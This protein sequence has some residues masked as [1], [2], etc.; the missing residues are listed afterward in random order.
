MGGASLLA[1]AEYFNSADIYGLDI[2]DNRLE[3]VKT[4]EHIHTRIE[5]ALLYK[6]SFQ[7]MYDIII[8]DASHEVSHQIQHFIDFGSSVKPSGL[9]IIEDVHEQHVKTLQ[10][11]ILPSVINYGFTLEIKDLRSIKN[12]FDDILFILKKQI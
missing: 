1:Y 4:H 10:E 8:E 11:G 5:D 6:N 3:S 9:Y 7:K 12:R 2:Q